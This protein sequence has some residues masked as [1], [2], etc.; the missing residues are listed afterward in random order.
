MINATTN[1]IIRRRLRRSSR[2]MDY[3]DV[4]NAAVGV[5]QVFRDSSAKS[6]LQGIGSSWNKS[7]SI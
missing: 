3:C 5:L 6:Y 2:P 4:R 7:Y 1:Q